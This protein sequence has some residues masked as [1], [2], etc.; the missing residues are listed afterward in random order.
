MRI[1]YMLLENKTIKIKCLDYYTKSRLCKVV[2]LWAFN[3]PLQQ[4]VPIKVLIKDKMPKYVTFSC[5]LNEPISDNGFLSKINKENGIETARCHI[6]YSSRTQTGYKIIFRA[7]PICANEISKKMFNLFVN[8]KNVYF[9][10]VN[11]P[12]E[13]LFRRR[14]TNER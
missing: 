8:K 14:I 4:P 5:N 2:S 13:N 7:D 9:N 12:Y 3:L 6:D 1:Q 10:V 11:N